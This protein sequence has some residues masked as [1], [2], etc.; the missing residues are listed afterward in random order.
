M[1]YIDIHSLVLAALGLALTGFGLR[2]PVGVAVVFVVLQF[3]LLT[4]YVWTRYRDVWRFW[5]NEVVVFLLCV[6]AWIG[7]AMK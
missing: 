4:R 6:V 7:I 5:V 3:P 2:S 1:R